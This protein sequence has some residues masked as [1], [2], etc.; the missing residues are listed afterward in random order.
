MVS[1][2]VATLTEGVLKTMLLTKL[3][4]ATAL[5]LVVG[6]LAGV[7][8]VS[9]VGAGP[10]R[11]VRAQDS[12]APGAKGAPKPK[13]A[14]P[15]DDADAKWPADPPRILE[16]QPY[17]LVPRHDGQS[18]TVGSVEKELQL[19][20]K[21]VEELSKLHL[22]LHKLHGD[23]EAAARA[24]AWTQGLHDKL[25]QIL[26]PQQIKRFKQVG[27]Q[28]LGGPLGGT[29]PG[30][31]ALG[32]PEIQTQL[33]FSDKQKEQIKAI[34]AKARQEYDSE[35]KKVFDAGGAWTVELHFEHS[36]RIHKKALEEAL[37]VLTQE[38]KKAWKQMT[39]EPFEYERGWYKLDNGE[40]KKVEADNG[41]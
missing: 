32:Y 41:G 25:L 29:H 36:S 2:K 22:E 39:G 6:A 16:L 27:L 9:Q 18:L 38:Q 26:E 15:E 11:Y 1:A 33:K 28:M 24:R 37:P 34:D 31:G 5:L 40:Y 35:Q 10:A 19:S 21:Q 23:K 4:I 12:Q 14:T 17:L 3:K 8:A 30:V 20:A 7:G 13:P